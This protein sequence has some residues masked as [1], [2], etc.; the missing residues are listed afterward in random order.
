MRQI[1]K[2]GEEQMA[3]SYF[4]SPVRPPIRPTLT[5]SS[6]PAN[7]Y[8]FNSRI[9]CVSLGAN[10]CAFVPADVNEQDKSFD[11][12]VMNL[13]TRRIIR[14]VRVMCEFGNVVSLEGNRDD[15]HL[16][17]KT[18]EVGVVLI[19]DIRQEDAFVRSYSCS[20]KNDFEKRPFVIFQDKIHFLSFHREGMKYAPALF[21]FESK[22]DQP[23]KIFIAKEINI[24]PTPIL[25]LEDRNC[26]IAGFI[27]DQKKLCVWHLNQPNQLM[28]LI[29]VPFDHDHH[30][31]LGL[32]IIPL[33]SK[34]QLI[35]YDGWSQF[36]FYDLSVSLSP[37]S[38]FKF[39]DTVKQILALPDGNHVMIHMNEQ[40]IIWSMKEST[41]KNSLANIN[42]RNTIHNF[43]FLEGLATSRVGMT[44]RIR[45]HRWCNTELTTYDTGVIVEGRQTY[46]LITAM[47]QSLEFKEDSAGK[48]FPSGV[49]R[50]I[51]EYAEQTVAQQYELVFPQTLL[52]HSFS[53]SDV[54]ERTARSDEKIRD[55]DN[56][57]VRE[58]VPDTSNDAALAAAMAAEFQ[59]FSGARRPRP[60]PPQPFARDE[61]QEAVRLAREQA[62]LDAAIVASKVVSFQEND[63]ELRAAMAASLEG[64]AAGAPA[65]ANR[66]AAASMVNL[67]GVAV[68]AKSSIPQSLNSA[69]ADTKTSYV[70]PSSSAPMSAVDRDNDADLAAAI[71]ASLQDAELKSQTNANRNAAASIVTSS[72]AAVDVKASDPRSLLLSDA[73]QNQDDDPELQAALAASLNPPARPQPNS[74]AAAPVGNGARQAQARITNHL[75]ASA[76]SESDT[77]LATVHS[78]LDDLICPEARI[79]YEASDYQMKMAKK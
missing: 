7:F 76:I 6:D 13:L 64:A 65:N 37:R 11:V 32:K 1:I 49:D 54:H 53:M 25:L 79:D 78:L 48:G 38:T 42:D 60:V 12:H 66:S 47:L 44:G 22:E 18:K 21:S 77:A 35:I 33:P 52:S 50:I 24:E 28:A 5:L 17:I 43:F 57:R 2:Y 45:L 68:D 59:G 41:I 10:Y 72:S 51:A 34:N 56:A 63:A 36:H 23:E 30:N 39:L 46:S 15:Y 26:F 31:W 62:E 29:D 14:S 73:T 71:A 55:S 58:V 74:N 61:K 4:F 8:G 40:I 19:Y 20:D 9:G 27:V 69:A 3:N 67:S 16:I 70:R 75:F